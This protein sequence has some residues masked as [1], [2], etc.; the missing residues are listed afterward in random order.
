MQKK[1]GHPLK[2]LRCRK[3]DVRYVTRGVTPVVGNVPFRS[4]G[5]DKTGEQEVRLA[6]IVYR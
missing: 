4:T 2:C 6:N 3:C 1:V 5:T